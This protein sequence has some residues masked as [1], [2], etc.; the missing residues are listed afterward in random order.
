MIRTIV[1]IVCFVGLTQQVIAAVSNASAGKPAVA[2]NAAAGHVISVTQPLLEAE[3][4]LLLGNGDL[5]VSVYQSKDQIRWRF[6]KGDVW[7][8]RIDTSDDPKPPHI[9]EIAHGI[10]EEGWKCPPYGESEPVALKG[11]KNPQRMRGVVQRW[12]RPATTSGPIRVPSRSGSW[13]CNFR[14]ICQA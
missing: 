9:K 13:R 8:R 12:R 10:A 1:A 4:G 14:P 11:T 5:S 3:D 2:A 6:G 7:D